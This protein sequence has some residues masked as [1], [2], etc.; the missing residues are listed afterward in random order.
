MAAIDT[1]K[2]NGRKHSRAGAIRVG[3]SARKLPVRRQ[4]RLNQLL[5]DVREKGLSR[6][7]QMELEA[8]LDDVD[9]KSFWMLARV[10]LRQSGLIVGSGPLPSSRNV[11]AR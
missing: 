4:R 1:K 8:M 5:D 2:R 9:R 10:V 7:E 3:G 11:G 6:S